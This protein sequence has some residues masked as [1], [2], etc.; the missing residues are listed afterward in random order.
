MPRLIPL[1]NFNNKTTKGYI[2]FVI[3]C[4]TWS[5][6]YLG[7]KYGTVGL[8]PFFMASIRQ[9]I[10]GV[11]LLGMLAISSRE[12]FPVSPSAQI[13][14]PGILMTGIANALITTSVSYLPTGV[15]SILVAFIPI[16]IFLLEFN[17]NKVDLLKLLGTLLAVSGVGVL[18]FSQGLHSVTVSDIKG[19][20]INLTATFC[21][22]IGLLMNRKVMAA[23]PYSLHISSYQILAAGISLIPIAL[24]FERS[25]PIKFTF[26]NVGAI[27]Y[28][29][30]FGSIVGFVCYNYALKALTPLKVATSAYVIPILSIG[31]GAWLEGEIISLAILS[32]M[33]LILAGT[34]IINLRAKS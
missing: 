26:S 1:I 14:W 10:A 15:A 13:I 19:I 20:G 3:V 25:E 18:A 28:L 27:L 7:M 33:A 24:L 17:W 4:V 22:A 9:T 8:P 30:L 32:A 6:T 29:A 16:W 23:Y 31:L 5:T 12:P 34:F 21:W 2:A 11:A